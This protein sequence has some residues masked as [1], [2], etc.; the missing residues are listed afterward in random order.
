MFNGF[1]TGGDYCVSFGQSPGRFDSC[2]GLKTPRVASYNFDNY[3]LPTKTPI[4]LVRS[5]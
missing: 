5:R 3:T 2:L 1:L 4:F